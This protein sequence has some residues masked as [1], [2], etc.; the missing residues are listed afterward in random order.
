M[1]VSLDSRIKN[2]ETFLC[3]EYDNQS[4]TTVNENM[5][6]PVQTPLTDDEHPLP[7]NS[8]YPVRDQYS[9][10]D[11][12]PCDGIYE[13][14]N[15]SPQQPS[16]RFSSVPHVFHRKDEENIRNIRTDDPRQT[17]GD[18]LSSRPGSSRSYIE[19]LKRKMGGNSRSE[20]SM[21]LSKRSK[22]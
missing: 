2:I 7:T 8:N 12:M 16:S 4:E 22:Y 11:S 5:N 15:T 20:S 17:G 1:L 14:K 9:R 13:S 6:N 19:N 10:R 21:Q 3:E 18:G